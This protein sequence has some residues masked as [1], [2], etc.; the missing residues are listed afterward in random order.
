M[1]SE[2]D[3]SI[4]IARI[5]ANVSN[6]VQLGTATENGATLKYEAKTQTDLG[7]SSYAP[8]QETG[9][10][11]GVVSLTN[12][13]APKANEEVIFNNYLDNSDGT[14]TDTLTALT[15]MRC[16]LGQTWDGT[17]CVGDAQGYT[18][19]QAMALRHDFAT[20]DK[21]RLP[22]IDELRSLIDKSGIS[23]AINHQA[24]PMKTGGFFWS[25]SADSI[26]AMGVYFHSGVTGVR[27]RD[28]SRYIR[29]VHDG[30][31]LNNKGLGP[32]NSLDCHNYLGREDNQKDDTYT[33][34]IHKTS[35]QNNFAG[36]NT[37]CKIGHYVD[38][39]DG[40]VTDTHTGLIW[41]RCALGQTWDGKSCTGE[42]SRHRF[43][44]ASSLR[45]EYAN[46]SDWRLPTIEEL[47]SLT[48]L[49]HANPTIDTLAFPNTPSSYPHKWFWSSSRN[50]EAPTYVLRISFGNGEVF[51]F[52]S[53]T[54]CWSVRLV[55]TEQRH[56]ETCQTSKN[57]TKEI[58][59]DSATALDFSDPRIAILMSRIDALEN[60]FKVAHE[61]IEAEIKQLNTSQLELT[62]E[63]R[64][65][66]TRS[67]PS[68]P[69]AKQNDA[70]LAGATTYFITTN[71]KAMGV[72]D[73]ATLITQLVEFEAISMTQLRNYLLPLGLMPNAVIDDINER[74]L[75]MVGELALTE[76]GDIIIVQREVLLQV[77]AG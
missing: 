37:K 9:E 12:K 70:P 4:V 62:K 1:N 42:V 15:W 72:V 35:E 32:P 61:R 6:P 76:D 41:M 59:K 51:S 53:H 28:N 54:E 39:S 14:V 5:A 21:W 69:L 73:I 10:Y 19:D 25:S 36:N 48:D 40:T 77:I 57:N 52:A 3:N 75:N 45:L 8:L 66:I 30:R 68:Q 50:I 56:Y 16:A 38:N 18:W 22:S 2:L 55:R 33:C 31:R 67:L 58:T 60:S 49:T 23:P 74:A 63:I 29:L 13:D 11:S 64:L 7:T 20:N 24:F 47:E 27:A 34:I 44:H 46:H 43:D 26:F 71:S 65:A 17:T